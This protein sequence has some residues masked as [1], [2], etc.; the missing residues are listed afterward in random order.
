MNAMYFLP[1]W[2]TNR[3]TITVYQNLNHPYGAEQVSEAMRQ[4]G[5]D[6]HVNQP[7]AP[8]HTTLTAAVYARIARNMRAKCTQPIVQHFINSRHSTI[9][10]IT[11]D[12]LTALQEQL[13]VTSITRN[14][15]QIA[16]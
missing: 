3:S 15:R 8:F 5:G 6:N 9:T 16:V 13:R 10:A 1:T 11:E 4:L 14:A 12:Q 7:D 2:I